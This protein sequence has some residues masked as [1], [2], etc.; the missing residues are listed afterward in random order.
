MQIKSLFKRKKH[1]RFGNSDGY[2]KEVSHPKEGM[3]I[4]YAFTCGG[5]DYYQPKDV[6]LFGP[7]R[8]AEFDLVYHE[9]ACGVSSEYLDHHIA[10]MEGYLNPKDEQINL[11]SAIYQLHDL[12]LRRQLVRPERLQYAVCSV[13]FFDLKEDLTSYDFAFTCGGT[14]YYQPMDRD[15]ETTG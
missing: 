8:I 7:K 3:D 9:Y 11:L 2:T 5:T 14:D 1:P 15:W 6:S 4:E 12:K 13:Y 10:S